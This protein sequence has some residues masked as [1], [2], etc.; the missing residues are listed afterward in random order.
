MT[1]REFL[2]DHQLDW[3]R[4]NL[5]DDEVLP[6]ISSSVANGNQLGSDG[7]EEASDGEDDELIVRHHMESSS[8]RTKTKRV[9]PHLVLGETDLRSFMTRF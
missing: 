3:R 9:S 2:L 6:A 1:A 5:A 8:T 4:E 7:H